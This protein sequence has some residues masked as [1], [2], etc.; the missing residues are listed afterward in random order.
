M[1]R[2]MFAPHW[3]MG[4]HIH[5]N[6]LDCAPTEVEPDKVTAARRHHDMNFGVPAVLAAT[7]ATQAFVVFLQ[8]NRLPEVSVF[9][10]RK[11][12]ATIPQRNRSW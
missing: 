7:T 9:N 12:C 10:V 8:Q 4:L 6:A 1:V 5:A 3:H 2:T 11:R